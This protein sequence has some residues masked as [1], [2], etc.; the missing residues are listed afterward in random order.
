MKSIN[1][2][3]L[4]VILLFATS[5]SPKSPV[6][7]CQRNDYS[8]NGVKSVRAYTFRAVN[9]EVDLSSKRYDYIEQFD[10]LGNIIYAKGERLSGDIF[11]YY[12]GRIEHICYKKFLLTYKPEYKD[13]LLVNTS[14]FDEDGS[15]IARIDH[16]EN[17]SCTIDSLYMTTIQSAS[18]TLRD[19]CGRDSVSVIYS[20]RYG[21]TMELERRDEYSY[22]QLENG[23]TRFVQKMKTRDDQKKGK[24]NERILRRDEEY[25]EN[26][27]L[28]RAH[29]EFGVTKG[30]ITYE[31][32]DNRLIA[33][34]FDGQ[35][36]FGKTSTAKIIEYQDNGLIK[37]ISEYVD[38]TVLNRK[39]VFEYDYYPYSQYYVS[40]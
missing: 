24:Y 21:G 17:Q 27:Q 8:R 31:Y 37:S 34:R 25:N 29:Y 2:R 11:A 10:S 26:N 39:T 7:L 12:D 32:D 13:T 28:V 19:S 16:F 9:G 38:G 15:Y 4:F 23:L 30:V 1:S 3:L 22:T 18:M 20:K 5:C 14:V 40:E 6:Q 35:S 33:E 36:F